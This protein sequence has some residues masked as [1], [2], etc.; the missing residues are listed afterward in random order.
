MTSPQVS[1][2]C[3]KPRFLRGAEVGVCSF[4]RMNY[5]LRN[6][7]LS[8]ATSDETAG[9]GRGREEFDL[10]NFN[11]Q[12]IHVSIDRGV[13]SDQPIRVAPLRGGNSGGKAEAISDVFWLAVR[14]TTIASLIV[15]LGAVCFEQIAPCPRIL[16]LKNGWIASLAVLQL[17]KFS[18]GGG[19]VYP[20]CRR[21]AG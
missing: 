14:R 8:S 18:G 21:D 12:V 6:M 13:L 15:T 19:D 3:S 5:M 17:G 9:G 1:Q 16:S 10:R 4:C 7:S 20:R 11:N 2:L